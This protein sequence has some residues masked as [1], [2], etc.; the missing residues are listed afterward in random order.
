MPAKTRK[1]AVKLRAKL[2]D[3]GVYEIPRDEASVLQS[4]DVSMD[5]KNRISLRGAS[6]TRHFHI[7]ELRNGAYL[8]VPRHVAPPEAVSKRTLRMLDRSATAL[9]KGKAS[10]PVDLARFKDL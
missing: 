1:K 5:T 9:K 2:P 10:A 3:G 6:I 7:T 8:L 4:Y